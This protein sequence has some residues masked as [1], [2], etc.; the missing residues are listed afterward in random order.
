MFFLECHH[1]IGKQPGSPLSDFKWERISLGTREDQG[2]PGLTDP[3]LVAARD[4]LLTRPDVIGVRVVWNAP[5]PVAPQ[6]AIPQFDGQI[7][8]AVG[9]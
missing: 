8:A 6:P 1:A 5:A 2:F 3:A 9:R 4:L 7:V